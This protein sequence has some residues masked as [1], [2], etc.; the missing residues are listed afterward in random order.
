MT[1]TSYTD[2]RHFDLTVLNK[3][4][5]HEYFSDPKHFHLQMD[6]SH[7]DYEDTPVSIVLLCRRHKDMESNDVFKFTLNLDKVESKGVCSIMGILNE[8]D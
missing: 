1:L 7:G 4:L 5:F 3:D 8:L 6:V 2:S